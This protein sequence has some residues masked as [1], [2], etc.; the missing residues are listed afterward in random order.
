MKLR[1]V[2]DE[3]LRGPLW[4]A[5]GRHNSAGVYPLD[6]LRV[7]DLADLPWVSSTLIFCCGPNARSASL[8]PMTPTPCR[9]I[10]QII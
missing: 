2:L 6:V 10:L 7:G 1:Y 9:I 4:R 5:I 3:H 8:S